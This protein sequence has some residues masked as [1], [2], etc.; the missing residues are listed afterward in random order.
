MC[1]VDIHVTLNSKTKDKGS[2][3]HNRDRQDN[4]LKEHINK[5]IQQNKLK[6]LEWHNL[7]SKTGTQWGTSITTT[8]MSNNTTT[9]ICKDGKYIER[10]QHCGTHLSGNALPH[11]LHLSGLSDVWSFWTCIL[12]S[13]LRPQVVGHSSQAYTG[14]LPVRHKGTTELYN[15]QEGICL[16]LKIPYS[17]KTVE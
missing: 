12:R 13:V 4:W 15:P 7:R 6:Q 2:S 17:T 5:K 11:F 3:I 16:K 8:M 14:L 9:A 1:L 10:D